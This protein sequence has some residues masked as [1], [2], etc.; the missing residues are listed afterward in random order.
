MAFISLFVGIYVIDAA[1]IRSIVLFCIMLIFSFGF[2]CSFLKR[3]YLLI[4]SFAFFSAAEIITGMLFMMIM[5]K[6]L[7]EIRE[8]NVIYILPIF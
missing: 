5:K 7:Y 2:G 6:S 1:Y 8:S 3:I 4:T